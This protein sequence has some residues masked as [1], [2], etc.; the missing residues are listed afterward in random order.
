MK[1]IQLIAL[2]V[3]FP[4]ATLFAQVYEPEY[5]SLEFGEQKLNDLNSGKEVVAA[6]R[7]PPKSAPERLVF[8]SSKSTNVDNLIESQTTTVA[9][10]K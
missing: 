7:I 9:T 10:A 8:L 2:L 4:L 3:L 5:D 6:K 1:R